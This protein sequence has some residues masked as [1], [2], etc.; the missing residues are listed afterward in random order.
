MLF[1]FHWHN[2]HSF[3]VLSLQNIFLW[4]CSR[5]MCLRLLNHLLFDFLKSHLNWLFFFFLKLFRNIP[6]DWF[7]FNN[8]I[9]KVIRLRQICQF[10]SSSSMVFWLKMFQRRFESQF[11]NST[12]KKFELIWIN[13]FYKLLRIG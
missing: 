8:R 9:R 3:L 11:A 12:S 13:E 5:L 7:E 1:Y 4:I 6:W 2:L 10:F